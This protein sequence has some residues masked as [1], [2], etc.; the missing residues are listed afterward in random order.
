MRIHP[1]PDGDHRRRLAARAKRRRR[2]RWRLFLCLVLVLAI[3]PSASVRVVDPPVS[4]FMAAAWIHAQRAGHGGFA[5]RHTLVPLPAISA[6]LALAVI[7]AEDQTFPDH[8]GFDFEQV[9]AALR[10]TRDGGLRGA[11][12]LSQQLAKNLF[13]WGDRSWLRKGLEAWYALW[14]EVFCSKRRILELYLNFVEF[15]EGVYGAE[16]ASRVYLGKSARHLSAQEAALL[17]AV[18]P[19]P[20]GALGTKVAPSPAVRARQ[21]WILRQMRQLGG[22]DYLRRLH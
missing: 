5:L 4:A 19:S 2:T 8:F 7:A 21:A 9:A 1:D 22:V 15:G 3:A 10:E 11:S 17:A 14:L 13:L 6:Q 12:T 18:L 20:R 16:A